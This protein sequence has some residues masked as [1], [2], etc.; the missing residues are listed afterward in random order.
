MKQTKIPSIVKYLKIII[1]VTSVLG[2]TSIIVDYGFDLKT[3]Y[4]NWIHGITY[5][6]ISVFILYHFMNFFISDNKFLYLKRHIIEALIITLAFIE[7]ILFSL[8]ISIIE[9]IS[10]VFDI[11]NAA[12]LYILF[13]Q[14]F[15]IIGVIL[16]GLRYNKLLLRSK[17]RPARMFLLSFIATIL[18]G[19]GLLS[20]PKAT[21]SGNISFIDALFTSTS[22]VCVTGLVTLDT[23]EY[24]TKFG[25]TI[26][27]GLFQIGGLGLMTFTTFFSLFLSGGL[28]IKERILLHDLLDEEN[29]GAI[30]KVLIYL[31]IITFGIEFIGAG[32][33][34]YSMADQYSNF[35]EAAFIAV[36]HSVS[37]FCNAGFSVFT[38]GL[39]EPS[40]KGNYIFPSVISVLIIIGG[41]GFPTIINLLRNRRFNFFSMKFSVKT[42]LQTK[43]VLLTTLVLILM[44]STFTYFL[45]FDSSLKGMTFYEKLHASYFQ[46]V[47]SR[48]AGF[49]TI[50]VANFDDSTSLF[51]ML[52]MF[53][54]ASPGGTGGGI[55]TTTFAIIVL[56]FIAFIR[57]KQKVSFAKR[58][59]PKEV[60]TRALFKF[61]FALTIIFIGITTLTLFEKKPLIDIAFESFSA[62]GTVGLSKG[63]TETLSSYGKTVLILLMLIGRVGPLTF[64]YNF[65]S[66]KEE[67]A[68][69]YPSENISTV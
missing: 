69:D 32:I 58:T 68:V 34:Y 11:K 45:E 28:G 55:K 54:G 36:F 62:F 41:I 49:N 67:A 2:L 43:L 10:K 23:A 13:A 19:A 46:S 37:A 40:V 60:I 52:L 7:I 24:F 59:I 50:N 56:S 9:Q 63:L 16:G 33:I 47:S 35:K 65:V 31:V 14:L 29:I 17:I 42:S 53:I 8:G 6:V 22:A 18:I 3:E 1:L 15:I 57:N 4:E 27:L 61:F 51:Y 38:S 5:G 26:I 25:Q 64:I 39:C 66:E 44:G 12:L 21:I 20:L 30:T 48:T